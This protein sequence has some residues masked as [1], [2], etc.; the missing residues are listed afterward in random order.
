MKTLKH[1]LLVI[2]LL[3]C[4][5]EICTAQGPEG[6]YPS[7]EEE[8]PT[9]SGI[10]YNIKER[11]FF[12]GKEK[13]RFWS[14]ACIDF[15]L[16]SIELAESL[17]FGF[18]CTLASRHDSSVLIKIASATIWSTE[19]SSSYE[20]SNPSIKVD[21]IIPTYNDSTPDRA[22][23]LFEVSIPIDQHN[24]YNSLGGGFCIVI[25][26]IDPLTNTHVEIT[27]PG[28][29][30]LNPSTNLTLTPSLPVRQLVC[31]VKNCMN[32]F[33]CPECE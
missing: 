1:L 7:T 14:M 16:D 23:C 13:E 24:N 32:R 6:G 26:T 22:F 5:R 20:Y 15:A 25:E 30:T 9:M 31:P 27:R 8:S 29:K 33:W 18:E 28:L 21:T 4:T 12:L 17:E 3:T 2:F 19:D 10:N 11:G